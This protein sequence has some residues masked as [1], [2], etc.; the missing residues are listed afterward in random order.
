MCFVCTNS[1]YKLI[2]D[3]KHDLWEERMNVVYKSGF[4]FLEN[5]RKQMDGGR[6]SAG[7]VDS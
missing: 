4:A 3:Q 7:T 5:D 2:D 1:R 6:I